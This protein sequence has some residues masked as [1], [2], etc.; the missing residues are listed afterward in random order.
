[1]LPEFQHTQ[2]L[3]GGRLGEGEGEGGGC[4]G[5]EVGGP[6]HGAEGAA[7]GLRVRGTLVSHTVELSVGGVLSAARPGWLGGG[8]GWGFGGGGR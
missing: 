8:W 1:M 7:E 6:E 2:T 3:T 5:S 4:G